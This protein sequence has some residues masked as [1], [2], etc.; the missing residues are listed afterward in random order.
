MVGLTLLFLTP[1]L[2]Y[3]PVATLAA[4]IIVAVAHMIRFS[5]LQKAWKIEKHDAIIGY[6]TF[7]TTLAFVPNIEIGVLI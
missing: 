6:I 5:P 2:A 3:L 4:I 1:L 7:F